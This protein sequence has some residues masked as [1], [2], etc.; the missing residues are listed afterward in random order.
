METSNLLKAIAALVFVIS[1]IG[2]LAIIMRKFLHEKN[3]LKPGRERRMRVE[4]VLYLDNKRRLIIV[5]KDDQEI[6]L[7]LGTTNETVI[8]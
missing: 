1:L 6:V 3:F 8:K 7:L 5:K 2:I 4:E